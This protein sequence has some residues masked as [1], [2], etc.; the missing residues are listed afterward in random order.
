MTPSQLN[1]L[2]IEKDTGAERVI[3]THHASNVVQCD[4]FFIR[5]GR[6]TTVQMEFDLADDE[7]FAAACEWA[8][9]EAEARLNLNTG[10][11]AV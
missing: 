5:D 8:K 11:G 1:W 9:F 7:Q 6:G 10:A 3:V 4:L 2:R